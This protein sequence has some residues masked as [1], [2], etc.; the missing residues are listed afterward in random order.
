MGA[1][2]GATAELAKS[3]GALL[4]DLHTGTSLN[5]V[6][7]L[8]LR[9]ALSGHLRYSGPHS[10]MNHPVLTALRAMSRLVSSEEGSAIHPPGAVTKSRRAH[11]LAGWTCAL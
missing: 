11:S 7:M 3:L 10:S 6:V 4:N 9:R 1:V 2:R 8:A 5:V